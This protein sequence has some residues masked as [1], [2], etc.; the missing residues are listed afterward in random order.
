MLAHGR[1]DGAACAHG[2][3][4]DARPHAGARPTAPLRPRC[5]AA[6]LHGLP[7]PI[8]CRSFCDGTLCATSCCCS[9]DVSRAPLRN[10]TLR[11]PT[12]YSPT[13]PAYS[14]SSPAVRFQRPT[15]HFDFV[16]RL[17][18]SF[19]PEKGRYA[20]LSV[21]QLTHLVSTQY[22]PTHVFR[23]LIMNPDDLRSGLRNQW[24]RRWPRRRPRPLR[25]GHC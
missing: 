9:G 17:S 13:S 2:H 21:P 19:E 20:S 5:A 4:D 8:V 12:Q 6:S 10:L 25:Q 16:V 1:T 7:L 15:Q 23:C 3:R 11:P 14:P 24:P 22:S 18:T